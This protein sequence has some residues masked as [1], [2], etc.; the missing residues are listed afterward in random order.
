[1]PDIKT[2]LIQ[3]GV[4]LIA[5]RAAG[6]LLSRVY[7]PRVVGEMIAGIMLGPSLLGRVAPGFSA[8]VFP[9]ESLPTL[10]WL[11]QVGLLLFM[12]TVGLELDTE[13]L[14]R[15]GR[16][17]VV[18]SHT[19]IVVPFALGSLLA[20]QLYSK[21]ADGTVPFAGFVLFTGVAMSVTAFPVLARILKERDLVGTGIGTITIACAAVDDVTAWCLLAVIIALIKSGAGHMALW[22]M[23]AGLALYAWLMLFVLGPLVGRLIAK[24]EG[25]WADELSKTAAV[26]LF[27][28][29]SSLATEWLGIHALFGAFLA[30]AAVPKG[31]GVGAAVTTK[32]RPV[33]A[34]LIPLFFVFSGLR[35][36]F[37]LLGGREMLL[38]CGLILLVAVA[39]KL[40]GSMAAARFTGMPWREAAAVGVLMNTRGLIELVILN[41]GLDIGALNRPLF[42]M[43]VVMAVC[44]TL[45]TTPLLLWIYPTAAEEGF[46]TK[47]TGVLKQPARG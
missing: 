40:G 20:L 45:M 25:A 46:F 16:S 17:A 6:W 10:N 9:P 30:G 37:G 47:G 15:M 18:I 19:S 23:F 41:I 3:I 4:I 33:V 28:L 21:I 8:Y 42:S 36:N 43:M 35:T 14:R 11:S 32:L 44:T 24:R 39:G 2:L 38:Y 5:A 7:Q 22:Q 26:I 27:M 29:A 13:K 34:V 31:L 12:F 1:M